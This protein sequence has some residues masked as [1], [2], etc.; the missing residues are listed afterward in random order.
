[1]S[2]GTLGALR[3]LASQPPTRPSRAVAAR[4]RVTRERLGHVPVTWIDRD[5]AR[6]GTVVHLHGGSYLRGESPAHWAWL[7]ELGR[8]ADVATAMVH[9]R[10]PPRHPFPQALEDVLSALDA[11][12]RA[13]LTA[14]GH[15]VL[16]GDESGAALALAAAQ[17][18]RDTAAL[19]PE[20]LLLSA[21]WADLA[22][23]GDPDRAQAARMYAGSM[24]PED[25]RLSPVHG[26]LAGLAPVH[27]AVGGDDP[28]R[29]GTL[30]L[31]ERLRADG[32][33][34]TL[35]DEPRG[36]EGFPIGRTDAA[37]QAVRR[38]QISAVRRAV[39][40][41]HELAPSA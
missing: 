33:E 13:L 18:R 16:S 6:T 7:E 41:D 3:I 28:R 14:P 36:G 29:P 35:Q 4:P 19:P 17:V 25:P 27:L 5:K 10:M 20:L 39:G 21:P 38:S 11:M 23:P 2:I 32:V 1:M 12:E 24:P 22:A 26:D 8:R 15:W 37:S 30:A 40:R 9:F 31:A 34:L